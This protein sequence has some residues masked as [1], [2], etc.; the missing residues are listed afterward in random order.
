MNLYAVQKAI[1][2]GVVFVRAES[3]EDARRRCM[4]VEDILINGLSPDGEGLREGEM[5]E[6]C[7]DFG[8]AQFIHSVHLVR[9]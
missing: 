9:E 1:I 3:E 6:L 5:E 4:D 8:D 2:V 7:D